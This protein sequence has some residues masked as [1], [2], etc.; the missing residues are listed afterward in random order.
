MKPVVQTRFGRPGGNCWA[1]S[2]ASILELPLEAVDWSPDMTPDEIEPPPG[3]CVSQEWIDRQQRKLIE[4][5]YWMVRQP[6]APNLTL[7]AGVHYLAL[8]ITDTGVG[9]VCVYLEG[10]IVHDPNPKA[11]GLVTVDEIAFLVRR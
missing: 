3:G 1:A 2:I 6:W 5:G 10:A 9:H 4:L 7:P 11:P 8:G